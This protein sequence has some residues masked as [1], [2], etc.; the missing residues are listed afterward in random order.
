MRRPSV[1]DAPDVP[2]AERLPGARLSAGSAEGD[3]TVGG[4]HI[5]TPG[6]SEGIVA[7]SE[8]LPRAGGVVE[9][10]GGAIAVV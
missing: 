3:P 2:V 9:A 1:F 8:D 6:A 10:Q 7:G 4:G 5:E